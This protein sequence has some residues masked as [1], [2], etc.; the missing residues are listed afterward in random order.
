[1]DLPAMMLAPYG[2]PREALDAVPGL[3]RDLRDFLAAHDG[4]RGKVG[5]RPMILWS[6]EQIAREAESQ[7]VSL[8]I[9]GLLLFGTDGG[10]L[11]YGYLRS[12]NQGAYGRIPL[13]AAGV[14]EFEG[15]GESLNDLLAA[16][17]AGR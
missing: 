7:E 14:H 8:A 11:G 17:A 13:L 2:A 3:P 9:A 5:T 16:L 10:A 4:G 15:F 1:M 6:A 12:G